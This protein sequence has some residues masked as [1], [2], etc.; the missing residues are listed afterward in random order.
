ML[1]ILCICLRS[2]NSMLYRKIFFFI[3]IIFIHFYKPKVAFTDFFGDK[4]NQYP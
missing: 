4:F 2:V 1:G 3:E